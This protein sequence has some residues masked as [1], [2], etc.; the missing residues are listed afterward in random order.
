MVWL[1][2][3]TPVIASN[4]GGMLAGFACNCAADEDCPIAQI[5]PSPRYAAAP[6]AR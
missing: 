2:G 5:A 1:K 4:P 3:S 6:A